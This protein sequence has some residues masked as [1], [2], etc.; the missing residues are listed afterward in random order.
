[1]AR[2]RSAK[3][4]TAVRIRSTPPYSFMHIR[5]LFLWYFLVVVL[6][7]GV[8]FMPWSYNPEFDATFSGVSSY[9]QLEGKWQHI[10]GRPV[11]LFSILSVI[12]LILLTFGERFFIVYI[13]L[14]I[15]LILFAY[16]IKN[17]VDFSQCQFF[18]ECPDTKIG[19]Y[20]MLLLSG[21]LLFFSFIKV[22]G[23]W[24]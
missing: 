6:L 19:L 13:R 1:M 14:F 20:L 7:L 15:N 23:K 24:L 21:V 12:N 16:A 18:V 11:I 2:Q 8:C 17:F 4:F 3:P 22:R 10:Y 5:A 9:V